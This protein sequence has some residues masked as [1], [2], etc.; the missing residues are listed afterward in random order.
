MMNLFRL[1]DVSSLVTFVNF[2]IIFYDKMD[3]IVWYFD[4]FS[5]KMTIIMYKSSYLP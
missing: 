3:V 5:H 2:R 4:M 1:D